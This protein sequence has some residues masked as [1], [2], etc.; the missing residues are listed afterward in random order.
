MEERMN[1][2]IKTLLLEAKSITGAATKA[3]RGMTDAE[4]LRVDGL[5]AQVETEKQIVALGGSDL[6]GDDSGKSAGE[7]LV[8][9]LQGVNYRSS[10][11]WTSGPVEFKATLTSTGVGS[12]GNGL[13]QPDVQGGIL[14]LLTQPLSIADL[15]GSAQTTGNL[16]RYMVEKTATS[17]AAG[18]PESGEKPESTLEFDAQDEPVRKIATFLPVTDEVL[19]DVASLQAYIN[20][21][22]SLF[23]KQELERQL[24]DGDDGD[25]LEGLISR[26]PMDHLDVVSDAEDPQAADHIYAGITAVRGAFVEPD[27]V[28]VHPDDWAAIQ[29][30]KDDM[31]RYLGS[32]PFN[33]PEGPTIWGK[34][35][36]ITTAIEQGTALVG[37]FAACAAVFYRG[38]VSV[39][40]SNSHAD[41]FKFNRTAIRAE[42]RCALAVY[43]P[44]GFAT[45]A[46][47]GGS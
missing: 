31:G 15:M 2:K 22:L 23:V 42:M 38:G 19:E 39:E 26:I 27:G 46:L 21:R 3:G 33:A 9:A 1:E 25:E 45:V 13:L 35:V 24:L 14:P 20:G 29:L 41:Y 10:A 16:V 40:A 6:G 12:E 11:A 36:V 7:L 30:L 4:R 32:G 28:V 43:R 47:D 5:L 37:A 44:E 18:V 34:R 8:K 17:G